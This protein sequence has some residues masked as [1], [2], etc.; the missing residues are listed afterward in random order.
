MIAGAQATAPG[1]P[2]APKATPASFVRMYILCG[3]GAAT[4]MSIAMMLNQI[5]RIFNP[6][7]LLLE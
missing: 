5:L 7:D 1:L 6:H 4:L 2:S 3:S